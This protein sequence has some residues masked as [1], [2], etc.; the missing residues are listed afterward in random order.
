MSQ[1][2]REGQP[3]NVRKRP[4]LEFFH[5]PRAVDLDR[6]RANAKIEGDPFVGLAHDQTVEYVSFPLRQPS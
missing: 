2:Q 5:H 3:Y 6:P 1:A 4:C